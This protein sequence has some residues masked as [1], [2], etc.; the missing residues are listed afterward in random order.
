M[1]D[2]EI[3]RLLDPELAPAERA[4]LVEKLEAD[5]EAARVLAL[6]ATDVSPEGS[7]LSEK[8][9]EELLEMV[10]ARAAGEGICPH[11]AGD[12]HPTGDFCP[13]C[14][15]QIRGNVI[16]CIKC[17]KP[18]REGSVYCPHCGTF[19][20]PIGRKSMIDSPLFPLVLGMVS[21]AVALFT[22]NLGIP[23]FAT[24]I[25]IGCLSLGAWIGQKLHIAAI[26]RARAAMM[27]MTESVEEEKE[28]ERKTG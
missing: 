26:Q 8:K 15:A 6:A 3:A 22:F 5:P 2:E 16:K 17:G 28:E 9:I 7:G 21:I 23:L 12:L 4:M 13:H 18:V 25:V 10:G 24:F 14:G 20:R 19:F 1:T 27:Q 11:C